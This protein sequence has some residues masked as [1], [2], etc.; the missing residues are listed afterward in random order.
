MRRR[1]VTAFAFDQNIEV[2]AGGP[3]YAFRCGRNVR[4]LL[5]K[6]DGIV[7]RVRRWPLPDDSVDAAV[8]YPPDKRPLINHTEL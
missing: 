1:T 4:P 6:N 7:G 5:G 8:A 3:E 2:I